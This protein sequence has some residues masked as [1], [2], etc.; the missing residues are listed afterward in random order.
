MT[1]QIAIVLGLMILAGIGA[2][3]VLNDGDGLLFL[4]KKF[5][6]LSDWIAFWR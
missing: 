4:A 5:W 1:N 6:D 2:D 3:I